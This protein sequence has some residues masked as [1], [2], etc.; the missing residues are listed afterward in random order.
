MYKM[1]GP[2]GPSRFCD[3]IASSHLFLQKYL[4]STPG[5]RQYSLSPGDSSGQ[6][7][8]QKQKHSVCAGVCVGGK[9]NEKERPEIE[10]RSRGFQRVN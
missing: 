2:Q 7:R 3:S 1:S 5:A 10:P 6:G 9:E 8:P 4:R